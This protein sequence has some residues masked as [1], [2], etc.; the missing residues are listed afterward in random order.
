MKTTIK[1][2]TSLFVTAFLLLGFLLPAA[3]AG[4]TGAV[5]QKAYASEGLKVWYDGINNTNG[6]HRTDAYLWRDLSGHANH[7]DVEAE[8]AA[9]RITWE[10]GALVI[11]P[12]T[13]SRLKLLWDARS[14]FAGGAYTVE[15]VFGDVEWA[16]TATPALITSE[17]GDLALTASPGEGGR[18]KL[19]Y[20]NGE[21]GDGC[22][23]AEGSVADLSGITVAITADV[24]GEGTTPNAC[25]YADGVKLGEAFSCGLSEREDVFIGHVEENLRWGGQLH[26]VRI[27][28]RALS[29]EELTANAAADSF[30][31]REGNVILP[32]ER[33]FPCV[34]PPEGLPTP[35]EGISPHRI[36]INQ[37]T[38][39]IPLQGFYGASNLYDHL[40]PVE[41]DETPWEGARVMCTEEP[42]TWQSGETIPYVSFS[43]RYATACSRGSVQPLPLNRI[44]YVVLA[45]RA[46]GEIDDVKL[47]AVGYDPQLGEVDIPIQDV[48]DDPLIGDGTGD[49]KYMVFGLFEL[50][51]QLRDEEDYLS[52]LKVKI[53]GL[54]LADT[55][56]LTEMALFTT[57]EEVRGYT[58]EEPPFFECILPPEPEYDNTRLPFSEYTDMIPLGGF[59]EPVNL[60]ESLYPAEGE[61]NPF[62]GA[63]VMR[64]EELAMDPS[65]QPIPYVSFSLLY[66]QSCR[67]QGLPPYP[68]ADMKYVVLAYR[69]EGEIGDVKL[70][71]ACSDS[72]LGT[73]DVPTENLTGHPLPVDQAGAV[74]YLVFQVGVLGDELKGE[75]DSLDRLKVQI[76]GLDGDDVLYLTELSLFATE[77]DMCAYMGLEPAETPPDTD[78]EPAPD[79]DTEPAPETDV[80]AEPDDRKDTDDGS[81]GLPNEGASDVLTTAS[82]PDESHGEGCS[83]A[84]GLGA[85]AVLTAVAAVAALKRRGD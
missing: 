52:G 22:A 26:G 38:D 18:V 83:S 32:V 74:K 59:Y 53:R 5:E 1:R 67:R 75:E 47:T 29:A 25:L 17:S 13:G 37:E 21:L 28:N 41:S 79:T 51:D 43:I 54:D 58:G 14:L 82:E 46:D 31:Y 20:Q 33:Y 24:T 78:T 55:L 42:E 2:M 7:L 64:T 65:G 56:Y 71:L 50:E 66:E 35:L 3:V 23:A 48:V 19:T 70:T 61:A 68:L 12:E 60:A 84:I 81:D 49:V 69:A 62:E 57:A 16:D 34:C 85:V 9:E 39:M 63:R 6:Q 77:A 30:N 44:R 45:Y 8:L 40:Y 36:P 76:D 11:R 73:F 72:Q 15:F 10:T 27:Y 80:N 4:E